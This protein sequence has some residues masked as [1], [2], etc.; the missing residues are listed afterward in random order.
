MDLVAL[1]GSRMVFCDAE[2]WWVVRVPARGEG[3]A[4]LSGHLRGFNIIRHV[5]KQSTQKT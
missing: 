3:T 4:Y 2:V 1:G 5:S